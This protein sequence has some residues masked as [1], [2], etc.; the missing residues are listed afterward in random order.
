[1]WLKY[2]FTLIHIK[3]IRGKHSLSGRAQG[4]VDFNGKSN[5]CMRKVVFWY[6]NHIGRV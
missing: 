3:G 5:D 4:F 1:M 6:V 2:R